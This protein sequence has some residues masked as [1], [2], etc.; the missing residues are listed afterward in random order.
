MEF[1][2]TEPNTYT[3]SGVGESNILAT[4]FPLRILL[5]CPSFKPTYSRKNLNG[6]ASCPLAARA[7]A[8]RNPAKSTAA[9]RI[10]APQYV[11]IISPNIARS[12]D[13]PSSSSAS[14][15]GQTFTITN[16]L[17]TTRACRGPAESQNVARKPLITQVVADGERSP[18]RRGKNLWL[19]FDICQHI[20][21][22]L[23]VRNPD[24]ARMGCG[25]K[26]TARV[27]SIYGP[28]TTT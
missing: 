24:A 15:C 6:S 20:D 4:A 8:E 3:S 10:L 19:R 7:V 16:R 14:L 22:S 25:Y 2:Y 1:T 21:T 26:M 11:F 18:T 27:R 23:R 17:G 12:H 5:I 28:S 13:A 9:V